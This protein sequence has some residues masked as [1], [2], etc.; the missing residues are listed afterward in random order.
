MEVSDLYRFMAHCRYGVVSSLGRDGQ[1]HSA[2]VGIA[3]TPALEI[4]FDTLDTS[5]KYADL[6]QRPACSVVMGWDGEQTVQYEGS[7]ERLAE[8]EL[9]RCQAAYFSTWP[10]GRARSSWPHI[11]YF[12]IRP[13]WIRYSDYAQQPQLIEEL[14]FP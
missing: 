12:V 4:I 13:A 6:V 11:A 5:R 7:A 8:A 14:R 10:E 1:P 9:L 2:L 3:V